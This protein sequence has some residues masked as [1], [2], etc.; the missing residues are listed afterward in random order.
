MTG[1]TATLLDSIKTRPSCPV[2]KRGIREGLGGPEKWFSDRAVFSCG[3]V[4]QVR[5]DV[6]VAANACRDRSELAAKLWTL[7]ATGEGAAL[8]AVAPNEG[9][10]QRLSGLIL[11][12]AFTATKAG[13]K[14]ATICEIIFDEMQA[15]AA[16]QAEGAP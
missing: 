10:G 3:A 5:N 2:C 13:L 8:D 7:Q 15:F 16:Q 11:A 1:A 4:F 6:I 14:P 12:L 9:G